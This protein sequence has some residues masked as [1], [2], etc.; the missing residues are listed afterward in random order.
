M[1]PQ[2]D[3][4]QNIL[5]VW[6]ITDDLQLFI[7]NYDNL[8]DDKRMNIIIGIVELYSLKLEKTF[9]NFEKVVNHIYELKNS[10]VTSV[11]SFVQNFYNN[12]DTNNQA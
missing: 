7:D 4:E 3:L 5:D 9:A 6:K 12:I 11:D 10:N 1:N 8:T 2:F